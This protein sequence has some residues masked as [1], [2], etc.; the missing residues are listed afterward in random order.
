[1]TNETNLA[2]LNDEVLI[3]TWG[4]Y[5]REARYAEQKRFE[6]TQEVERRMRD[7]RAQNM[8]HPEYNV[9]IPLGKPTYDYGVLAQLREILRPEEYAKAYRPAYDEHIDK[10]VPHPENWDGQQINVLKGLGG[11]VATI[12]E[13]ATSRAPGRVQIKQKKEVGNG[14]PSH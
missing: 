2:A 5:D 9:W 6:V 1:M 8:V 3:R 7:T 13:Q 14:P 4:Y 12:I 10:V 11:D